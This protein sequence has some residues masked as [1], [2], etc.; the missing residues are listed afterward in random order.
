VNFARC[1]ARRWG[2]EIVNTVEQNRRAQAS[3]RSVEIKRQGAKSLLA[4][5][6]AA[7]E[8]NRHAAEIDRWLADGHAGTMTYLIGRLRSGKTRADPARGK[9]RRGDIDELL[10]WVG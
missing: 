6:I 3:S 5:G 2:Y 10:P 7:L 8:Q 4:V 1:V 9:M